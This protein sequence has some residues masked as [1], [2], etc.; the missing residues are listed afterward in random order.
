M[1]R[2]TPRG[3][4]VKA[5]ARLVLLAAAVMAASG[6]AGA[7]AQGWGPAVPVKDVDPVVRAATEV[8]GM[9]R[10][11]ALIIGQVNLPEFSGKGTMVDL[12]AATPGVPVE[13]SRYNYAVAIHLP[14]AR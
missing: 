11:R 5:D 13:V 6:A 3:G 14:A 8:M 9:V 1:R 2:S 10:T 7:L 12:E 4:V